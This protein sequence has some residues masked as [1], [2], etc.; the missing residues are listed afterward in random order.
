M[1]IWRPPCWTCAAYPCQR[2]CRARASSSWPVAS[3]PQWRREWLYDYYEYPGAENVKPHRGIRTETH[4]L[5]QWYTQN[6]VEWEMYDLGSDPG[7]RSN[8]YGDP[9]HAALQK[10]LQQRL[11]RLLESTPVRHTA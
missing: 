6:P 8:L 9:E 5:I 10:D 3:D 2:R 7:E 1:S 4:K 11:A